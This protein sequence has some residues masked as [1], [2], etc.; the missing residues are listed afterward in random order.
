MTDKDFYKEVTK[1]MIVGLE[2]IKSNIE[3]ESKQLKQGKTRKLNRVA[4]A[5]IAGLLTL[6]AVTVSAYEI[7]RWSCGVKEYFQLTSE[8]IAKIEKKGVVD[9][10]DE[11]GKT[12]SITNNGVTISA[13]QTIVDNYYAYVSFKVQG[14]QIEEGETPGFG[15]IQCTLD[16]NSVSNCSGFYDGTIDDGSGTAVMADGSEIPANKDGSLVDTYMQKDGTLEYHIL[17]YTDGTKGYFKNK[18]LKVEL[19]DLGIYDSKEEV[20]VEKEGTWSFEWKLDGTSESMIK[21]MNAPIGKT[22]AIVTECEVS[23][24]TLRAVID[25]SNMKKEMLEEGAEYPYLSGVKL[26]DGT[27]LTRI[28]EGGRETALKRGKVEV[29][30]STNRIIDIEEVESFLFVKKGWEDGEKCTEDNFYEISIID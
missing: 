25:V 5:A 7:H 16:E 26:K 12:Q 6:S 8:D 22:G 23:P 18:T 30:F 10:P 11:K 4:V 1:D 3:F 9:F 14:Y 19:K 21:K 2:E 28:T 17:L 20:K 29:L 15:N 24:I 13:A 27:L